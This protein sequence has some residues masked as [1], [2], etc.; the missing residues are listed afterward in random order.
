MWCFNN[1]LNTLNLIHKIT[2]NLYI[3]HMRNTHNPSTLPLQDFARKLVTSPL[4]FFMITQYLSTSLKRGSSAK[5][6]FGRII[7][8]AHRI[9]TE[10]TFFM[11]SPVTNGCKEKTIWKCHLSAGL[12]P[13]P[14]CRG[15]RRTVQGW[16]VCWLTKS[17]S[18][19]MQRGSKWADRPTRWH[20]A[21][22]GI[23]F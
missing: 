11:K 7:F 23:H 9:H 18:R 8:D 5:W 19:R 20:A 13:S 4:P 15:H 6:K 14:H 16:L 22:A 2:W 21:H 17:G 1:I 3:Y 12:Q 10:Y